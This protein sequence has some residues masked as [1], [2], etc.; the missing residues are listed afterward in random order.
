MRRRLRSALAVS[1]GN[2]PFCMARLGMRVWE[3]RSLSGAV[4]A[5][6]V[7]FILIVLAVVLVAMAVVRSFR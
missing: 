2:I 5:A 1:P 7:D 4:A 3:S 6:V